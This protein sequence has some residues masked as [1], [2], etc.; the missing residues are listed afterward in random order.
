MPQKKTK[1]RA[2]VSD[3]KLDNKIHS[4]PNAGVPATLV[5]KM[6]RLL[7]KQTKKA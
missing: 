4:P 6:E 2:R 7:A 3:K 1:G 5:R